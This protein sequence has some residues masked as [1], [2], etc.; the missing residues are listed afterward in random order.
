MSISMSIKGV[1]ELQGKLRNMEQLSRDTHD[2]EVIVG[3]TAA[4]AVYVH[5]DMNASHPRGGQAKFLE[6]PARELSKALGAV[7]V[8]IVKK[9]G[10]LLQGLYAAGLRL[11]AESQ[12]LVPVDT[13]TLRASAFTEVTGDQAA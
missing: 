12:K 1:V 13:G 8:N 9:G 4:Y 7:V 5:E 10:T 11:Q 2:V 3:Y 6:Q